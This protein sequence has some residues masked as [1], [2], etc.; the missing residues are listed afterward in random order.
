MPKLIKK[1]HLPIWV[2]KHVSAY[3]N[4]VIFKLTSILSS[5]PRLHYKVGFWVESN[6]LYIHRATASIK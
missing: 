1:T 2:S 3:Y 4:F 5:Y 6:D